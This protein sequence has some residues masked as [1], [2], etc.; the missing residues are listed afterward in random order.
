MKNTKYSNFVNKTFH[1]FTIL[2]VFRDTK[3]FSFPITRCK[4]LCSCKKVF[5]T[6]LNRVKRNEVKS[7]GHLR[8]TGKP[9]LKHGHTMNGAVS[10]EYTSWCGI[11]A[12]CYHRSHNRYHLYGGRGIKCLWKSFEEFY[13]DMGNKPTP[14]HSIERKNNNKHYCK[15]NCRWATNKEQANNRSTNKFYTFNGKRLTIS[16]W[17]DELKLSPTTMRMRLNKW[18]IEK[19][20]T[21]KP[22]KGIEIT[23]ENTTRTI[24]EWAKL[25]GLKHS[26]IYRRFK[27]KTSSNILSLL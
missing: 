8:K 18:S 13:K 12:R 1:H 14:L 3:T 25:T 9:A 23:I 22:C 26:T 4:C 10:P 17:A 21:T 6:T 20:L 5:I 15:N 24:A 11:Q 16:Q 27:R 7:C 19:A 2:G